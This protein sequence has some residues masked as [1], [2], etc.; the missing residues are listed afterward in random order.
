MAISIVATG[1]AATSFTE[2]PQ[3][4]V[5]NRFG[6]V[7]TITSIWEGLDSNYSGFAPSLGSQPSFS[8]YSNFYLISIDK[9]DIGGGL[10][11]V[12]L[13]YLGGENVST[14]SGGVVYSNLKVSVEEMSKSFSWQGAAKIGSSGATLETISVNEQYGTLEVTL[15]YTAYSY[16]NGGQFRS[17]AAQLVGIPTGPFLYYTGQ[18]L[19]LVGVTSYIVIPSVINPILTLSRFTAKQN[20]STS[21][22]GVFP[23]VY[24][25][26]SI[27]EV[28]ET[29]SLEYNMGSLGVPTSNYV[30]T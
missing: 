5:H 9:N 24:S 4:R 7:E 10:V 30:F 25:Q 17:V 27:W 1:S 14:S 29:W 11:D 23:K 8:G 3:R 13:N 15:N 21:L 6:D 26:S 22:S 2:Q 28:Q 12:S 19:I 20:S 18:L 16:P